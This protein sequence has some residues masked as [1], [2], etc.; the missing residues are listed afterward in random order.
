M[1]TENVISDLRKKSMNV[2]KELMPSGIL[3]VQHSI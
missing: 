2:Q 1:R 3:V